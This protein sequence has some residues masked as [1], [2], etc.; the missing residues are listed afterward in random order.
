MFTVQ[1]SYYAYDPGHYHWT[2]DYQSFDTVDDA[3]Q[4]IAELDQRIAT[5]DNDVRTGRIVSTDNLMSAY[6]RPVTRTPCPF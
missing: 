5:G 3:Q 2:D 1:Y 6:D 4:F